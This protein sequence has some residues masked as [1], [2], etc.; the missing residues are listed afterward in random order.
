MAKEKPGVTIEDEKEFSAES[1]Y[2]SKSEAEIRQL[3]LDVISGQVFG[4]WSIP[5]YERHNTG[6]IFMPVMLMSDIDRKGMVRDGVV[7]LYGHMRDSF[8]RSLNGMPLFH[9][10]HTLDKKD[11]ERL[12]KWIKR[13]NEVMTEDL[14]ANDGD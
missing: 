6:M 10:F 7:H 3:A 5:E 12:N 8:E 1:Q 11:T 9:A 13:L 4:T 14:E 2:R